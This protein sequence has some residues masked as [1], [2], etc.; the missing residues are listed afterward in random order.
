MDFE[1]ALVHELQSI[2]GLSGKVFPTF[3]EENTKPPMIVYI[4]SGGERIMT[5]T[6]PTNLTELT[7]EIHIITEDYAALKN[8]SRVVL[9]RIRSFFQRPIGKGGP[10]IKSVSHTEP[11]E[12]IDNNTHF[13][14]SSF[15]IRIRF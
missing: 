10:Y 3:A 9:D 14:Q 4:S 13:H 8:L 6:G 1:Q 5:L 11:T 7:C 15:D 2:S 12:D